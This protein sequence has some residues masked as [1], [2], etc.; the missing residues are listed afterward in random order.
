VLDAGCG[1]GNY[2]TFLLMKHMYRMRQTL[3]PGVDAAGYAYVGVDF[4]REAVAQ[5]RRTHAGF[6]QEFASGGPPARYS[7]L[8]ADLE[9]PLP[10]P[11]R[12][13][14]QVCMNLVV[15]YLQEPGRTLAD[16]ARLLKPKGRI[17]VTSLKPFADL[18]QVYRNYISVTE[19]PRQVEEARKLLSNA[20]KVMA[21]EAEGIYRFFTEE[22]LADLLKEAGLTDIETFRAF[23]N[24][25]NVAFGVV[26]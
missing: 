18:S 23:G 14:D 5:A 13:F 19:E 22:E 16:M 8:L 2:G 11:A 17:V 12:S 4:V 3:S 20:G 21:K 1:I 15:S 24:Q 9:I 10:F 6:S 25:A 7:Y 26:T